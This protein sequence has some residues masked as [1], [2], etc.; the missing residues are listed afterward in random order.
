MLTSRCITRKAHSPVYQLSHHFYTA[1]VNP[2][3]LQSTTYLPTVASPLYDAL[4]PISWLHVVLKTLLKTLAQLEAYCWGLPGDLFF[5]IKV[6]RC[7]CLKLNNDASQSSAPIT[8]RRL[9]SV[10]LYTAFCFFLCLKTLRWPDRPFVFWT[11]PLITSN[12]VSLLVML[13]VFSRNHTSTWTTQTSRWRYS[14]SWRRRKR[15]Y[16]VPGNGDRGSASHFYKPR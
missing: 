16:V 2:E 9:L 3:C 13:N 15:R 12:V 1:L 11:S 6:G 5:A 4:L 8:A 7:G 10:F 14:V